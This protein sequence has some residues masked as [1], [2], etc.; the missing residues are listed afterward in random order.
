MQTKGSMRIGTTSAANLEHNAGRKTQ[1]Q[2]RREKKGKTP[3]PWPRGKVP[4]VRRD[5]R[6]RTDKQRERE[7]ARDKGRERGGRD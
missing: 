1:G 6:H 4:R 3:K 5:N 2:R 7:K